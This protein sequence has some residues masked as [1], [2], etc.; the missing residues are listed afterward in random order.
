MDDPSL[1]PALHTGALK[2]LERINA[3]SATAR[4]LWGPLRRLAAGRPLRVL[5]VASG[6]GDVAIGLRRRARAEG[7]AIEVAGCDVSPRAVA[8]AR[9]RAADHGA[10]VEFFPCDVLKDPFPRGYDVHVCTLFLHH[11]REGEAVELLRRM[12]SAR[13]LLVSDLVRGRAGYW[14]ARLGTRL[15]TRSSIVHDDA[16]TSVEGAFTRAELHALAGAAG[17]EGA[18]IRGHWP[19]RMLLEWSRA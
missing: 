11:L 16:R 4:A 15:L 19:F 13:A 5:D 1:D 9:S 2:G 7:L 10:D 14:A 17:L 18:R 8:H 12:S 6:A 3:V